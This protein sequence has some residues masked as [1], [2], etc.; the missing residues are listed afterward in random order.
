MWIK[1]ET[2]WKKDEST[3]DTQDAFDIVMKLIRQL[4]EKLGCEVVG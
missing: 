4:A 1:S 3:N 2:R